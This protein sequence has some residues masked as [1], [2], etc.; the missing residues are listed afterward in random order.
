MAEPN[1]NINQAPGQK[2][3]AGVSKLPG[4]II[5]SAIVVLVLIVVWIAKQPRIAAQPNGPTRQVSKQVRFDHLAVTSQGGG[6]NIQG[7]ATNEGNR[8][9]TRMTV[10]VDFKGLNGSTLESPVADVLNGDGTDL[11]SKPLPPNQAQ[12]VEIKLNHAP[13]GWDQ[14]PP[15]LQ[16]KSVQ[17]TSE[18]QPA[19]GAPAGS[20]TGGG[21]NQPN[22]GR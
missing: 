16:V 13:Q 7:M 14:K 12:P 17:W 5:G 4:I 15:E 8:P 9:I 20:E 19:N 22:G 2:A 11:A 18:Q 21:A 1:R 10:Q 6:F 3:P